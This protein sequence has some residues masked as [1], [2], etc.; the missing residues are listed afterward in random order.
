MATVRGCN[1]P[2]DRFYWVE[3][4][5]WAQ[6]EDDGTV[7]IGITDVA[8]NMAKGIVNA[9]PKEA[10]RT[11]QRGKSAGT[12][13]SG[14]WVGPVT[15]PITGEIA[16]VNETMKAKPSLINS[17]PYGEGWFVRVKPTDWAGESV[18]LATGDTAVAAYQKFMEEQN[19]SFG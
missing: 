19:L 11:V 18:S 7:T 13:E 4:H 17:D 14:K 15:S 3:K 9:T 2:E 10:G 12:L 16:A 8:Q 6:L 5:V 1:I